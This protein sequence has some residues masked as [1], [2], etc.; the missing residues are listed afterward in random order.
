VATIENRGHVEFR[1]FNLCRL[2]NAWVYFPTW[3]LETKKRSTAVDIHASY[4]TKAM[5]PAHHHTEVL[6][7]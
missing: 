1:A 2:G 6:V 4:A 5:G 3:A 7:S